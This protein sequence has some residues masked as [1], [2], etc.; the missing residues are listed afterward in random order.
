MALASGIGIFLN[1]AILKGLKHDGL[2]TDSMTEAELMFGESSGRLILSVAD[3]HVDMI[4]SQARDKQILSIPM[5]VGTLPAPF[6]E[7]QIEI[8]HSNDRESEKTRLP[9]SRLREAHEGWLPAY[10]SKV[11]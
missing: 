4:Q 8:W 1:Q 10:M 11:E 3:K 6:D 9:L 5:V 7:Q 2:V